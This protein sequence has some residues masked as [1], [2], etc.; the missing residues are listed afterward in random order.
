MGGVR[1]WACN[2]PELTPEDLDWKR[3][4][5][6]EEEDDE[7][8]KCDEEVYEDPMSTESRDAGWRRRTLRRGLFASDF[9]GPLSEET[10]TQ[11]MQRGQYF[12]SAHE[13]L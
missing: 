13:E 11:K 7:G 8:W 5:R 9:K 6:V 3:K 10:P 2:G 4:R 1:L 12:L